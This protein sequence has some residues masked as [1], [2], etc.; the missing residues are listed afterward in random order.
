MLGSRPPRNLTG[1]MSTQICE[2][3]RH[4]AKK[5]GVMQMLHYDK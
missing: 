4:S 1:A 5:N 3:A 2:L